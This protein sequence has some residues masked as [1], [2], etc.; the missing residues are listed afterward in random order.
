[1]VLIRIRY[2]KQHLEEKI[3]VDNRKKRLGARLL[4]YVRNLPGIGFT[5]PQI[6]VSGTPEDGSKGVNGHDRGRIR[7][8]EGIGAALVGGGSADIGMGIL[9]GASPPSPST[10]NLQEG[11]EKTDMLG[12][13]TQ[14]HTPS[15]LYTGQKH[16]ETESP[17]NS[18]EL[19]PGASRVLV[20][21]VHSFTSSP[22]SG[23]A[24]L[25]SPT[26]PTSLRGDARSLHIAF[27][28]QNIRRR[29]GESF[30]FNH[31]M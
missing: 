5:A 30:W 8:E 26:S 1:M 17:R 11:A 21:D 25:P 14:Y 29:P 12:L 4:T 31:H 22:R 3:R 7:A 28:P 19:A 20:E 9:L 6:F 15:S 2:F 27:G 10:A 18:A 16:V 24:G 23:F 13:N